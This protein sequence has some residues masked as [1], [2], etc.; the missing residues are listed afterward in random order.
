M[1]MSQLDFYRMGARLAP[2]PNQ[3]P[4]RFSYSCRPT[5][6]GYFVSGFM[7]TVVGAYVV[8]GRSYYNYPYSIMI[9]K[10]EYEMVANKEALI[11]LYC[12]QAEGFIRRGIERFEGASS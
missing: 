12:E 4:I 5:D 3:L 10:M 9:D 1:L 11:L 7:L 8:A 2:K 6:I